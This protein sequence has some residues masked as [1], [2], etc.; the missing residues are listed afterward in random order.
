MAI[1]ESNERNREEAT[2][3]KWDP[4]K[5]KAFQSR[6]KEWLEHFETHDDEEE[7]FTEFKAGILNIL[8]E[9]GLCKLIW[10]DC[11]S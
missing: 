11:R 1:G 8:Q 2:I 9:L 10:R 7:A 4:A 5:L 3:I 6:T